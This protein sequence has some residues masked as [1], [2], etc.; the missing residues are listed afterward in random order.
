MTALAL[1]PLAAVA[2]EAAADL[3]ARV[4]RIVL[5]TLGGP[6]YRDPS[7]RFLFYAPKETFALWRRPTF[8]AHWIVW[9]DG[10]LWPRH[11]VRGE[12]AHWL[13]RVDRP[14]DLAWRL[15]LARQAAPVYS[16]VQDRNSDTIGIEVAHS[17]RSDG[18][19]PEAQVL[20]VAWLVRTLLEMSGG[21]LTAAEVVGHKD[22]DDRPAYTNEGC[23]HDGCSFY[24]DDAGRPYRR[25]VDP[26]ESLFTALARQGLLIPREGTA[27]DRE[28]LRGE[29][30]PTDR[31]PAV[32][33]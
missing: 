12:P 29:A 2:G 13:P 4:K 6:F 16:H 26:P 30:I 11:A 17:G 32:A 14:A 18:P 1:W 25:R 5:H 20:T 3:P 27:G 7:R 31:I 9:T 15:R 22:L 24:V 21:R 28:L 23:Q 33:R 10:S 19:F 8:G